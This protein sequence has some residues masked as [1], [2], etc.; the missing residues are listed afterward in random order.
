MRGIVIRT[1]DEGTYGWIRPDEGEKDVFIHVRDLKDPEKT[2]YE[3]EPLEFEIKE[4]DKGLNAIEARRLE[5]RMQGVVNT[6]EKGF[7]FI[8]RKDTGESI[9]FHKNDILASDASSRNISFDD[10]VEFSVSAD[11][12]GRPKAVR[13]LR[14]KRALD[15]FAETE[16]INECLEE[17]AG[18]AHKENWDYKF[19]K[20]K[21]KYPIL[22]NY[23]YNTF[24]R[25]FDE[26]KVAIADTEK[27]KIACFNTGLVTEMQEEI[28]GV[29][30][31]NKSR[32]L[33]KA[34]WSL[35]GFFKK[36]DRRLGHFG[37]K[38]DIAN[39]FHDPSEL[40]YDT[41][42]ELVVNPEHI[43]F[44]NK[45]RFPEQ[46]RDNSF[47]LKA[48][49]DGTIEHAKSRVRRNYKTA[50]P[51]FY[52]NRIQLLLPLCLITPERA[53]LALVIAREHEVY[54]GSTVLTLDMAYN[55]ARLIARPDNEWLE[56]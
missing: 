7:G 13:V 15:R 32:M 45:H 48:V 54:K 12:R 51:Q 44:D 14:S 55:N 10:D 42:I 1:K 30:F 21:W 38:P 37:V 22:Y 4:T 11:E 33:N 40:L 36:S 34:E 28:F 53:D 49:L 9:F 2:L 20:T 16:E 31:P 29:F 25:I 24:D 41:R 19:T 6:F 5:P 50:I 18:L 46:L 43:I 8:E 17:L 56:P 47:A 52:K 35:S 3:N 26:K 27:G 39:Y 23:I